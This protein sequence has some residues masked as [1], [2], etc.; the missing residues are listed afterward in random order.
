MLRAYLHLD[1]ARA[2]DLL[3][4]I[5]REPSAHQ[6]QLIYLC[7]CLR[8]FLDGRLLG[9]LVPQAEASRERAWALYNDVCD[10]ASVAWRELREECVNLPCAEIPEGKKEAIKDLAHMIY[11]AALQ[12]HFAS[13]ADDLK[14]R[15]GGHSVNPVAS[16]SQRRFLSN[17]AVAIGHL[18]DAGLTTAAQHLVELLQA[19]IDINPKLVFLMVGR[20]VKSSLGDGYHH[21]SLGASVIVRIVERYL[22]DYRDVLREYEDCQQVLIGLLDAFVNWPEARKLAYRLGEVFR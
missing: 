4:Q 1:H 12:L 18:A 8:D 10:H 15:N 3:F 21:E 2:R 7:A 9:E 22:A 14:G 16:D 5:S 20:I 11:S 19:Y 13:G 17:A 6:A